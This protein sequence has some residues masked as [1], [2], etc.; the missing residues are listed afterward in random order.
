MTTILAEYGSFVVSS[1]DTA[2]RKRTASSCQPEVTT[3][4]FP[5]LPGT[6]ELPVSP[7]PVINETPEAPNSVAAPIDFDPEDPDLCALFNDILPISS[8]PIYPVEQTVE[9]LSAPYIETVLVPTITRTRL[10]VTSINYPL[11]VEGGSVSLATKTKL[12]L[13]NLYIA[14]ENAIFAFTGNVAEISRRKEIFPVLEYFFTSSSQASFAVRSYTAAFPPASDISV[15]GMRAST[16]PGSTLVFVEPTDIS[17]EGLPCR[18]GFDIAI[19]ILSPVSIEVSAAIPLVVSDL[20]VTIPAPTSISVSAPPPSIS[21]GSNTSVA[22]TIVSVAMLIPIGI[23]GPVVLIAPFT[24]DI[25]VLGQ[26]P[27]VNTGNTVTVPASQVS[28]SSEGPEVLDVTYGVLVPTA[29]NLAISIIDPVVAAGVALLVPSINLSVVFQ[30]P[31]AVT[32]RT[33]E[34]VVRIG[35]APPILGAGGSVYPP[36]GW[37]VR[38]NGDVDDS[39]V[40]SFSWAFD[41]TIDS[42]AHNYAWIGSNTYITFD[43]GSSAYSDLS[44]SN[45]FLNKIFFGAAIR[46]PETSDNSYQRVYDKAEVIEGISVRRIRYEGTANTT[47]TLGSPNIVAEFTFFQPFPDGRQLIEL[48]VGSHG[49]T[50]GLFM[51]ASKT[52]AYA[53]ST[54]AANSSWVFIGNETGTSWTMTPNRYAVIGN[55]KEIDLPSIEI[56]VSSNSAEVEALVPQAIVPLTNITISSIEPSLNTNIVL[57]VPS[58]DLAINARLPRIAL[59]TYFSSLSGQVYSW[60]R[61]FMVDWWAD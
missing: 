17:L 35:T 6:T 10:G 31:S 48:R 55:D 16:V 2:L 28:I 29:N 11:S 58:T 26:L 42:T 8:P 41:L 9:L 43:G 20:A 19:R 53:S 4:W 45:P 61:D 51:I 40:G 47:G 36:D 3:I 56:A 12:A 37:N 23:G 30:T 34:E 38:Q 32:E 25:L 18:L 24:V 27:I 1:S 57:E 59:D 54:I 5:V 52:T 46:P 7:E 13:A 44:E 22:P 49:R 33:L 60:D 50:S 21:T 15:R 39:S 14:A